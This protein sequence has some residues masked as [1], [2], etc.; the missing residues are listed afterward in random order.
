MKA[1]WKL[2]DVARSKLG[3]VGRCYSIA[4]GAVWRWPPVAL[5]RPF[6]PETRLRW[7]RKTED[8]GHFEFVFGGLHCF[9]MLK[10]AAGLELVGRSGIK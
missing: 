3:A 10:P 5:V 8:L 2:V 4:G 7:P 9:G 6:A 1:Q